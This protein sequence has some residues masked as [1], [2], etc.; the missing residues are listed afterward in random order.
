LVGL[1]LVS[2]SE[3][4][5]EGLRA[6]VA[7]FGGP[8]VPIALAGGTDDGRIG[9]TAPRIET[10][11]RSVLEQGADGALVLLDFGSALLSLEIALESLEPEVRSR[12]RI[13]DGPLVEGAFLAGVQA[14]TGAEL[15]EV[16]DAAREWQSLPKALGA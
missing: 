9:T 10:A 16:A 1:V 3:Q 11:I 13:S 12:V 5:V 8:E 15:D 7:Q 4:L 2:H 14:S 6:I